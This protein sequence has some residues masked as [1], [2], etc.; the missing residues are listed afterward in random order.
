MNTSDRTIVIDED[1][2]LVERLETRTCS[3]PM[4]A[5]AAQVG[6]PELAELLQ[7]SPEY[8]PELNRSNRR[9]NSASHS[10][11]IRP[12]AEPSFQAFQEK[13]PIGEVGVNEE[14]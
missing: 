9:Q 11:P 8:D 10:Q 6:S 1:S 4:D 7:Q 13:Q 5:R 2:T 14:V 3:A 12:V